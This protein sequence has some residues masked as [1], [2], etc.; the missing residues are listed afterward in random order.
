MCK[1]GASRAWM[2]QACKKYVF[3]ARARNEA[4]P[5]CQ[6]W[7]K[8]EE[9]GRLEEYIKEMQIPTKEVME[10]KAAQSSDSE[11]MRHDHRTLQKENRA[12]KRNA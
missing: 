4:R 12:R 8:M 3:N 9:E 5:S 6:D 11:A 10:R 2:D 7:R 1:G